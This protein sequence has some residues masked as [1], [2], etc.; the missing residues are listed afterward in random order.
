MARDL[1]KG[2]R[3]VVLHPSPAGAGVGGPSAG[4]LDG[5]SELSRRY[6]HQAIKF[7]VSSLKLTLKKVMNLRQYVDK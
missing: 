3:H 2:Q 7:Y 4:E 6:V 5:A 1:R